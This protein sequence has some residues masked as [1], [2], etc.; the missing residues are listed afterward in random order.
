ML[1]NYNID[2]LFIANMRRSERKNKQ[3]IANNIGISLIVKKTNEI[4]DI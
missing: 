4:K 2:D 3:V 1:N